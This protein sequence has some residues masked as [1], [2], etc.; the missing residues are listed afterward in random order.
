MP[1]LLHPCKSIIPKHQSLSVLEDKNNAESVAGISHKIYS[2]QWPP[3][4]SAAMVAIV[5]GIFGLGLRKVG[6]AP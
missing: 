3:L 4:E 6:I 5:S 2:G 1:G